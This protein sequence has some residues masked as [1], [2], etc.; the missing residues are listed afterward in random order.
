MKRGQIGFFFILGVLLLLSVALLF[1]AGGFQ[2]KTAKIKV[3][4]IAKETPPSFVSLRK[5][6]E[7]CVDQT[8]ELAVFYLGFI[9]G[10]VKPDPW[11][12]QFLKQPYFV[13]NKYYTIPYY[14]Y[15]EKPLML[16]D[17]EIKRDILARYM[18]I[19]LQKCTN[20][21]IEFPQYIVKDQSPS[22]IVDLSDEEVIFSVNYPVHA[23]K[24]EIQENIPSDYISR[25]NVRLKEILSIARVITNFAAEDDRLIHWDFMT[26]VTSRDYNITAYTEKDKTLIYRIIDLNNTIDNEHYKYQFGVKIK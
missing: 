9:G 11:A 23:A 22:T 7:S 2:Y 24:E 4:E 6:I 15:E 18:D 1:F 20:D 16:S 17:D 13:Y 10:D 25:I 26:D 14:T 8:A 5:L 3:H 12:K 19:N 21:F